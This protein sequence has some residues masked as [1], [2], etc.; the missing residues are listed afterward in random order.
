MTITYP[1]DMPISGGRSGAPFK[2]RRYQSRPIIGGGDA[3]V[4]EIAS[5]RWAGEWV[6]STIGRV[7]YGEWSAWVESLREG[8]RTFK[9]VPP[10]WK[11][12]IAYPRGFAGLVYSSL[13]WS[14]SGNLSVIDANRDVITINHLPTGFVLSA[15]DFL[16]IP[17]GSFHSLH[18]VLLGGTA[19]GGG[20]VSVT[21]EPP[22]RP[23]ISTGIDVLFEAPF[24]EMAI[25]GPPDMEIG[26]GGVGRISFKA[27]QVL[28]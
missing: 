21:V 28:K 9:G 27:L 18:K 3:G 16:S 5:S 7:V 12:P 17:A 13:P 26:P 23:G 10:K 24:C 22:I 8:R 1:R 2:L 25:E 15:G 6:V 4:I 20:S 11:W 14:G 19:N